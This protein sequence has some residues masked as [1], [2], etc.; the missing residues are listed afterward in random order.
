MNRFQ[1]HLPLLVG[2]SGNGSDLG[3]TNDDE[4]LGKS[5]NTTSLRTNETA[6]N[7]PFLENLPK[8]IL[9]FLVDNAAKITCVCNMSGELEYVN[10]VFLSAL[11]LELENVVGKR[12]LELVHPED[13][14][15]VTETLIRL[16]ANKGSENDFHCRFVRS[17]KELSSLLGWHLINDTHAEKVFGFA[18]LEEQTQILPNTVTSKTDMEADYVYLSEKLSGIGFWRVDLATQKVTWSERVF[19]IHNLPN[20]DEA[21]DWKECLSLYHEDDRDR[22]HLTLKH[23]VAEREP[24]SIRF[25]LV[26]REKY[27][28]YIQAKGY[29]EYEDD[30]TPSAIVGTFQDVSAQTNALEELKHLSEIVKHAHISVLICDQKRRIVWVNEGFEQLTGYSRDE[31]LGKS[32]AIL[33]QG[34]QTN[35]ETRQFIR[36]RLMKGETVDCD[37][38]NYTKQGHRYWIRLSITPIRNEHG[39]VTSYLGFQTDISQTKRS[40]ELMRQA[41]HLESLNVMVGGIAH[42]FNNVL[43]IAK[44]NLDLLNIEERFENANSKRVSNACK[45]I[46]RAAQLTQRLLQFSR[47]PQAEQKPNHIQNCVQDILILLDKSFAKAIECDLELSEEA[48]WSNINKTDLEDCLINLVLNAKDAME[49]RGRISISVSKDL[50]SMNCAIGYMPTS[51]VK[52]PHCLIRVTDTGQGISEEEL[53]KVFTPFYTT[54]PIGKGTGLGLSMV[55]NFA[56]QCHGYV[57]M[58]SQKDVGTTV[59]LWLPLCEPEEL[60][61]KPLEKVHEQHEHN[62]RILLLD[63][64]QDLLD[65][66]ATLLKRDGHDVVCS[67]NAEAA[68]KC[69]EQ[70]HFDLF[71]SDVL[72]PGEKQPIDVIRKLQDTDDK[73]KIMLMSGY[74]GTDNKALMEFPILQ[75]PFSREKLRNSIRDLFP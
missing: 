40:E 56:R 37:V 42:D 50:P 39:E 61:V 45:A 13:V 7:L 34:E 74:Q 62:L 53:D 47:T 69:L 10:P 1:I 43:G 67:N 54:K 46:E 28:K 64:E 29:V 5:I 9:L 16:F 38:L 2:D 60:K 18:K 57:G 36:D 68:L 21:P 27:Q 63:D 4:R 26:T 3:A 75:K 15:A 30:G 73:T 59:Y 65:I 32:P 71:L 51:P 41:S 22:V 12:F 23:A 66:T 6:S 14:E 72:M 49:G 70:G 24:F 8:H 33:L 44:S 35:I 11:E 52:E 25:R 55:F 19:Q 58:A 20:A 17:G 31:V 48:L